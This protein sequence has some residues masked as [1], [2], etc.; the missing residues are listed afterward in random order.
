[1]RLDFYSLGRRQ[2]P[3]AG[4]VRPPDLVRPGPGDIHPGAATARAEAALRCVREGVTGD[5]EAGH[6]CQ[7]AVF[8]LTRYA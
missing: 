6:G 5:G 7:A 3:V 4:N 2:K 1:M 8:R